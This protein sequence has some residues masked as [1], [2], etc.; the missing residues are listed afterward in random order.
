M[1]KNENVFIQF[2]LQSDT[3]GSYTQGQRLNQIQFNYFGSISSN[4]SS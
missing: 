3:F 4:A 2:Q 1:V